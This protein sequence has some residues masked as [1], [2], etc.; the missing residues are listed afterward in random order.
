M[1]SNPLQR[2]LRHPRPDHV[3]LA[4]D[5]AELRSLLAEAFR[6]SG[7]E[8]S[9]VPDGGRLLVHVAQEIHS[10]PGD[11]IDLIVSD[12]H[13]PICTG[14]QIV[15]ALRQVHR[16]TPVI[17]ITAFGDEATRA[18]AERLGA[19]LFDKPFDVDELMA[20]V[21]RILSAIA[22]DPSPELPVTS[23]CT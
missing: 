16:R 18:K 2:P 15:E 14:L 4:E 17:L 5:D 12:V 11:L 10:K 13:M 19:V 23:R 8:V 9:S 20:T 1:S 3:L 6:A 21:A 7:Y 22:I